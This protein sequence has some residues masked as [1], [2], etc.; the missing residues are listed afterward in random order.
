MNR[1]F[2]LQIL[3]SPW[4]NGSMSTLGAESPGFKS[5]PNFWVNCFLLLR[6]QTM[7][8]LTLWA[9]ELI[10]QK[11][12]QK[13]FKFHSNWLQRTVFLSLKI[14]ELLGKI[15]VSENFRNSSPFDRISFFNV[16]DLWSMSYDPAKD[17]SLTF[18]SVL[19]LL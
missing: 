18:E 8:F 6:F 5:R 13:F 12:L 9:W 15:S 1:I 3:W 16:L 11:S 4:P 2:F 10:L 7:L 17:L 19:N 14:H